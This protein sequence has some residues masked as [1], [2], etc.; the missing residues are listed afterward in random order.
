MSSI[1][2]NMSSPAIKDH[3]QSLRQQASQ[4]K[5]SV[6]S[7][8]E[9]ATRAAKKQYGEV[10]ENIKHLGCEARHAAQEGLEKARSTATEYL[11]QGR[12]RAIELERSAESQIRNRPLASI[13]VA[14]GVGMV[15]GVLFLR[16]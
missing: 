8:A 3:E 11:H 4:A 9:D 14:C 12:D 15:L 6:A 13:L 16:R 7:A 5:Q 2:E 10:V 1:S